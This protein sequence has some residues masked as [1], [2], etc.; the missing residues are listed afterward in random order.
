MDE[1]FNSR[2][3]LTWNDQRGNRKNSNTSTPLCCLLKTSIVYLRTVTLVAKE[4]LGKASFAIAGRC[5][6]AAFPRGIRKASTQ[7][8]ILFDVCDVR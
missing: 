2:D 8:D 6:D 1:L 7:S 4:C 3:V 5:G